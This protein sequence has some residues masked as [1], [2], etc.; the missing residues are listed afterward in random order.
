MYLV[1]CGM[2]YLFFS[3]ILLFSISAEAQY[4]NSSKFLYGKQR[5]TNPYY[6]GLQAGVL[7]NRFSL[8]K[9]FKNYGG[10]FS[11]GLSI[12]KPLGY[13]PYL[14]FNL[15]N[16]G[17]YH[18]SML[19]VSLDA[20]SPKEANTLI[21]I[22][23]S[24]DVS[25]SYSFMFWDFRGWQ[26]RASAG[27]GFLRNDVDVSDTLYR[28]VITSTGVLPFQLSTGRVLWKRYELEIGY[29]YYLAFSDKVDGLAHLN[30]FDKYTF[31]FVGVKYLIGEKDYRFQKK[32]SCP[33]VQ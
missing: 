5:S 31:A 7:T 3:F 14:I 33:T 18:S 29:R 2:K 25:A 15:R 8:N 21:S 6:I 4:K 28:N 32:G 22:Q 9:D 26:Y 1:N 27:I 24:L 20:M 16:M 30:T 10:D 13:R 12:E 17:N 11:W 23:H 19:N